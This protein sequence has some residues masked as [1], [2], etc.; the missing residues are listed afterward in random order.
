MECGN[1]SRF[2]SR[3]EALANTAYGLG[4]AALHA[5][6]GGREAFAADQQFPNFAPRAKRVIFLFQAGGPSQLDLLDYKPEMK[7][8]F[9]E[10]IPPSIFG[11]QRIT[12]M[13]A[14]QDRLPVAPSMYA[15]RQGGQSGAWFSELLPHTAKIADE[16]CVLRAHAYGG[17]QPRSRDYLP[18]NRES[19]ARADPAWARGSITALGARIRT[20]PLSLYS[21]H[22]R[23]MECRIRDCLLA[24]GGQAFCPADIRGCSSGERASRCSIFPT[25]PA[26]PRTGG[27]RLLDGLSQPQ[28]ATL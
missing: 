10:D 13:V 20:F 14:Q 4:V 25:R 21:I 28:R 19:A 1:Y 15:F 18:A 3:R 7:A 12:G 2:C 23:A 8:R 16:I 11:G 24:S 6:L 9:N 26:L 22:C 27:A 5:L 17:N